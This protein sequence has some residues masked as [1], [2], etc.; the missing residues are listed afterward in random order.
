MVVLLLALQ[1][2]AGLW[3][4]TEPFTDGRFH[5]NWGPP[6][7]LVSA[8]TTNEL[9]IIRSFFGV[10]NGLDGTFYSSHPQ[11]IGPLFALWTRAFGYDEWSP[12][13]FSLT[14]TIATTLIFGLALAQIWGTKFG[15]LSGA[16][17]AVFPII[18]VFGKKL[19]QEPLVLFFIALTLL[20]GSVLLTGRRFPRRLLIASL[21]GMMLSD[22]SGFVFVVTIGGALV[23]MTRK[24]Q[25][26]TDKKM[27][28]TVVFA[29]CLGVTLVVGQSVLQHHGNVTE[30]IREYKTLFLIRSATQSSTVTWATW[31]QAQYHYFQNNYTYQIVILA[32]VGFVWSAW[33]ARRQ[34]I[35]PAERGLIT[36]LGAVIAGQIIYSAAM[37]QASQIHEYFQYYFSLPFAFG[38]VWLVRRLADKTQVTKKLSTP[39]GIA[40]IA[41]LV[42][43]T[44][45]FYNDELKKMFGNASDVTLL[46]HIGA[47]IPETADIRAVFDENTYTWFAHPNMR[48]YTGRKQ[49]SESPYWDVQTAPYLIV[50]RI[51]LRTVFAG[52]EE[53]QSACLPSP[54]DATCSTNFCLLS[55]GV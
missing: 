27:L 5:Y 40:L 14:L 23:L 53:K 39:A 30:T 50:P 18:Y 3:R 33:S 15:A 51:D 29:F 44:A 38:I 4:I 25:K 22:W 9:G 2:A 35:P 45:N 37:R 12:R 36:L 34:S 6:F 10:V 21:V 17:F 31:L 11:L 1:L 13:L 48:Y 32:T 46:R 20:G 43:H 8:K 19:D 54:A 26:I 49:I 7:W 52:I 16:L 42:W 41:V 47:T 24:S 28:R 55:F